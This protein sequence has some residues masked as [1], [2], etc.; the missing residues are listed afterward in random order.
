MAKIIPTLQTAMLAS[1]VCISAI[2][3]TLAQTQT[4]NPKF[5]A[6]AAQRLGPW[7]TGSSAFLSTRFLQSII[8]SRACVR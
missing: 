2:G 5:D 4:S 8:V 1:L 6:D 7:T 3:T